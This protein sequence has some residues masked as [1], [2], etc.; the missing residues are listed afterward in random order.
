[1]VRRFISNFSLKIPFTYG[2]W[3]LAAR[4]HHN[5]GIRAIISFEFNGEDATCS[6]VAVHCRKLYNQISRMQSTNYSFNLAK[7]MDGLGLYRTPSTAQM[8]TETWHYLDTQP[9]GICLLLWV[10]FRQF[11]LSIPTTVL[12]L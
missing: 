4:Y 5:Q 11:L 9:P 7:Y 8:T 10:K 2:Q 12:Q 3:K 6:S 1:M